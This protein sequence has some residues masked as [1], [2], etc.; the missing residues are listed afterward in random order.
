MAIDAERLKAMEWRNIGP[1]RGGRVVAVAGDP[2][3]PMTFYFGACAGG[4]WKTT[5]GGTY[6]QNVSDGFFQT[7]A[8]GAIEVAP[9]DGNVVYAG[10]GECCIRGDVSHGDGVYRSTDAGR[11]WAHRGLADTRHIARVRVHPHDPD[12]VFV[13]A[14]GHAFGPNEERGVFRSRDGGATWEK[15][16]YRDDKSGAIDLSIDPANPRVLYAAL[17]ETIRRPWELVSGG[18]GSGLYKSTDGGDTWTELTDNPGLPKGS[19]GRIGVAVSPARSGRVWAL[20]EHAEKGGLYRSDDGGATWE[21]ISEDREIQQRP[22]Y[23]MHVFADPQDADTCYILNLRMWKSTDGGKTFSPVSTPHGDNHDLWID[24]HN[25]LRMIEGN[26]GG[27][28][29]SFNGGLTFSTIYNQPTAEFYHVAVDTRVPYHVYGT[30]Q[31]NSA[32]AVP[33]HSNTGAIPW[34]ECYYVGHSESGHIQV[35]PDNPDIIYSG[36]IGSSPGGGGSLLRYDHGTRQTQI[37][38]VWPEV[39]SGLGAG[40]AKYRFQW[41]YPILISPHDPNTLYV[42]GN[43]VFRTRDE[44]INWEPISPD[45]TRNDESK[46]G[47]SGGPI[48]KDTTGAEHYC[49][50]F[51]FT[52]SR[53]QQGLFWAGSDDGLIHISKDGGQSWQNVTPPDLPEWTTINVI[54]VSPHDPATAYVAGWR[55][56]LHDNT[57][58][59]WKT[60]DYGQSWQRITSGIPSH[61]FTRVIREDPVRRGLLY[62]GTETGLYVSF[63]DGAQWQRFQSNLPVVPVYDLTVKGDDLVAATHGR[64]FWVLDDLTPLRQIADEIAEKEAHL[65]APRVT[66]RLRPLPGAGRP[67]APGQKNYALGLGG[68]ATFIE[69]KKPDGD[70][71]RIFIDAGTNPPNGV[72]VNYYLKERPAGEVKLEFFDRDGNL[73]KTFTSK[74]DEVEQPAADEVEPGVEGEEGSEAEEPAATAAETDKRASKEAGLNRFVWNMRYPDAEKVEGDATTEQSVAGPAAAPGDY[75]VRLT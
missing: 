2:V 67:G 11:T 13:A 15:V 25:P 69:Q 51:A 63:D 36:A 74:A 8:V 38:T 27:A 55:Y 37:I 18:P 47:P 26:D 58:Y 31:D 4:V 1:H 72:I 32:I 14:L 28:C 48:T 46:L 57:P 66:H 10:M 73:V 43:Q 19:K 16:L 71:E 17:W 45:L 33:S 29:A 5:D 49:T 70:V 12:T 30:Q 41:T 35:R 54:E 7:A 61:D 68:V 39:T 53:H 22:W 23:Y 56:K 3:E 75:R 44:G 65:F 62:A 9:S 24:P 20:V 42:T 60:T 21:L 64:S 59:L 6:W 40:A 52:E 50:I 34:G